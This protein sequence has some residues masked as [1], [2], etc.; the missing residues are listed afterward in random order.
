MFSAEAKRQ[1]EAHVEALPE[2]L[3]EE[4][5]TE[6]QIQEFESV[7]G[8]IP[9]DFRWFLLN[10]G[11]GIFGAERV[12]GILALGRSHKKFRVEASRPHGWTL[13]NFFLLG[14]DGSGNPFGIELA[15][16]QIVVEDHNFG[17]IHGIAPSLEAFMLNGA[18][19]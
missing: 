4:P 18:W 15:T 5:A 19:A 6:Q 2:N 3:R 14:W 7:H 1:I 16:G 8:P 17:G 11:S 12:D 10:C 13:S 9:E